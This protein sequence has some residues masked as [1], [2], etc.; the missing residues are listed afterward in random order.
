MIGNGV[1]VWF[2]NDLR[3]A[4]NPAL[5]AALAAAPWVLPL[6][7]WAPEEEEPWAP[8]A[9]SRWWLH[10]SL[11][12]L[13][14][15][16][17]LLGSRLL[18]R[19]GPT[20]QAL[21]E[22]LRESGATNVYWNRR[23]EP[24]VVARDKMLKADLRRRG[25]AVETFNASLLC[26]PWDVATAAGRPFQVFTPYWRSA[27]KRISALSPSAAPEHLLAPPQWP[28][29][30]G[31]SDLHLEPTRDWAGGLRA[32]W[33]PGEAGAKEELQR[34]ISDALL[35]YPLGRDKPEQ[36][37]TSRL[38]PYLH[39]GEVSVGRV[40]HALNKHAAEDATPGAVSSVEAYCRQLGWREFAH[41]LLFHFPATCDAPLRP[42]FQSFP[43]REEAGDR[44]AWQAGRTGYPIVDAGMREL[45]ASGWMHN[46]VR[47]IAASFLVKDLLIPW[48]VGARWF[49]DTLVDAD[50]ANNTLGWQWSAGCG[51]DAA[52]FFR[53]FN[54]TL[55]GQRF[56][57]QGSYVRRWIPELAGVS[58]KWIH[59]P[60]LA[61][62]AQ[63]GP[64]RA[65]P[66]P[67]VDHGH[68]RQRALAAFQSIRVA[69][70]SQR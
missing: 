44:Q 61:S 15:S 34:F 11:R 31:L 12:E 57:P 33:R 36:V 13:D 40:W 27:L 29:S 66:A 48:Q 24:A 69:G 21:L 65:Y 45:W 59:Q 50:L 55:Q 68:A 42:E 62:E 23:Y 47:M 25:V 53:V 22:V 43:W 52:P 46:R 10:Q 30:L 70:L 41:H 19:R 39:F 51:A 7:I 54:P 60:W 4:D 26:E 32:V 58:E 56:D 67:I 1:V 3:L 63:A 18:L 8:G 28:R 35:S 17:R 6:F 16:L 14:A 49:W 38:S 64:A 5:R 9:A 2:R 37:G 20:R